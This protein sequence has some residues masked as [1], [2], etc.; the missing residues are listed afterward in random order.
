MLQGT[1]GVPSAP[2]GGI[3][4]V[5]PPNH[6]GSGEHREPEAKSA[7]GPRVGS[8]THYRA[9]NGVTEPGVGPVGLGCQ[10][11]KPVAPAI[12][13]VNV[14]SCGQ[15]SGVDVFVLAQI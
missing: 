12:F 9:S 13:G 15:A 11:C 8:I 4:G 14:C 6:N 5:G 3:S 1:S 7:L 10:P 2:A